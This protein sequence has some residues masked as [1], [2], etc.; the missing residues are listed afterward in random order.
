MECVQIYGTL[1][2]D[3]LLLLYYNRPVG[4]FLSRQTM[5]CSVVDTSV[6]CVHLT[7]DVVI[8]GILIL[9]QVAVC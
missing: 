4:I 1:Q 2:V 6:T 9:L 8:T 5:V 7:C 3:L